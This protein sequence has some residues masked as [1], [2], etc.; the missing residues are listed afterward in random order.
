MFQRIRTLVVSAACMV[1]PS[2]SLHGWWDSGHMAIALI[3]K[4][5]LSPLAAGRRVISRQLVL[6]GYRLANL[7]NEVFH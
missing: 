2:T 1:L 5:H 3:T 7:L 4:E 6:A